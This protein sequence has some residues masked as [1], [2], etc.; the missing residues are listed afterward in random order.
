MAFSSALLY[1]PRDK[2]FL[3]YPVKECGLS[4]EQW[5]DIENGGKVFCN[6]TYDGLQEQAVVIQVAEQ[7]EDLQG[8]MSYCMSLKKSKNLPI[9]TILLNVGRIR[10]PGRQRFNRI[11]VSK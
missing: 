6:C 9:E 4:Q 5:Q 1:F 7:Q 3:I 8:T 11:Q 10:K 2:S